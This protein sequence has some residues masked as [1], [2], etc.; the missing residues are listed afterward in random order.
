MRALVEFVRENFFDIFWVIL[1]YMAGSYLMR[2]GGPMGWINI[3]ADQLSKFGLG[4][5]GF[6]ASIVGVLASPLG[7]VLAIILNVW[8][9]VS[10]VK[11]VIYLPKFVDSAADELG[12]YVGSY[13]IA[14]TLSFLAAMALL[15]ADPA[16][17]VKKLSSYAVVLKFI[18]GLVDLAA[19]LVHAVWLVAL[20]ISA[21]M[22][23]S[24]MGYAVLNE[25]RNGKFAVYGSLYRA[26][27]WLA[28]ATIIVTGL[29]YLQSFITRTLWPVKW[30]IDVIGKIFDYLLPQG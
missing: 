6:L 24:K 21:G 11:L 27:V 26:F 30:A 25:A 28:V 7:V 17:T 16:D 3:V 15:S 18:P 10:L 12:D 8:G 9:F 22:S 19:L 23:A 1:G 2:Y 13:L 29:P 4:L 14:F 5:Q 20:S